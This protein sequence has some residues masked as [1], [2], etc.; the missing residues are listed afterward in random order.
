MSLRDRSDMNKPRLLKPCR[1]QAVMKFQAPDDLI[2]ATNPARLFARVVESLDLSKLTAG[3]KSVEHGGGRPVLCPGMLLTLWLYATSRGIGS[4]REIER[5]TTSDDGFKWIVGDLE[6][7][8]FAITEFRVSHGEA[9]LGLMSDVLAA[10]MHK[11]LLSLDVVALDGTRTRASASAPS[12]RRFESLV[13]CREQALLHIKAVLAD[14]DNPEV[15]RGQQAAREA[16][17][18]DI[19]RRTE[20]AIV[21]ACQL[22]QESGTEARAS[23]TDNDARVMKMPD[24]GFRPGYNIQLAVA[25]KETGGPRTIV[26]VDVTNLGSDMG[27]VTK[28]IDEVNAMTGVAPK[29]ILADGNHARHACFDNAAARGVDVLVP[30]S[31][32][33]KAH[34]KDS[35]AVTAWRE[36]MTTDDAKRLYRGRAA[37]VELANAHLKCNFGLDRVLVRGLGKVL[38]VGIIAA[39]TFNIVQHA[40]AFTS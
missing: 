11:G 21:T 23:T 4:A 25:G 40:A 18:R 14:A 12:F 15:T 6:V 10:L 33:S 30:P 2:D 31:K 20:E 29:H 38:C 5:L 3:V 24:G 13:E 22:E 19:L 1:R 37:L 35:A 36:R 8:R 26:G 7:G 39:L 17:A 9:L 28:M 16:A 34:A 32:R 27:A